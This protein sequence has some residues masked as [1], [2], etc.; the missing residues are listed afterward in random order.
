MVPV[1]LILGG[2][3][4]GRTLAEALRAQGARFVLSLA[5]RT[6]APLV[7]GRVRTGGFGGA[8]GLADYLR[9]EAVTVVVDATHPFATTMSANAVEACRETG[10]RLIRLDRP[11]WSG[12]PAASGWHWVADHAEA[13]RTVALLGS[14]RILLTVGRQ[15]TLD[16]AP[17]LSRLSV[18]ARVAEPPPG[19]LP[20]PWRLLISRGP[21][22]LADERRIFTDERIDCLVTKDSGGVHT[23]AKLT[24]A[25]ET[26]AAVVVVRRSGTEATVERVFSVDEA[27]AR[28]SAG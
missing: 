28:L 4:E 19:E 22:T 5:G 13:A 25:E 8:E 26:G 21:F 27:L 7:A 12:D 20:A 6:D 3:F 9:A 2:T 24:A 23:A 10:V 16:Y 18:L 1:I 15:H 11:G 14:R 17:A